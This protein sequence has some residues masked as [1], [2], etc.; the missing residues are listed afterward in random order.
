MRKDKLSLVPFHWPTGLL[1]RQEGGK[2]SFA[3]LKRAFR[4]LVDDIDDKNPADIA[5]VF[6]GCVQCQ[7]MP[8]LNA[9]LCSALTLKCQMRRAVQVAASCLFNPSPFLGAG[10]FFLNCRYAPLSIRL[11][12]GALRG[13]GWGVPDDVLKLLPGPAFEVVQAADDSGLPVERPAP[14]RTPATGTTYEKSW[15]P[16]VP[17]LDVSITSWL[18]SW[19]D[20]GQDHE[21]Y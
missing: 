21:W 1:R 6:S 17:I 4:L 18:L 19:M 16:A 14:P 9:Q 3:T 8:L 5:Y 2:G 7:N 12:E 15:S 13:A 11:V 20:Y 10:I